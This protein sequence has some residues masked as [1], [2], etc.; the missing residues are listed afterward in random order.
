M[1]PSRETGETEGEV[2]RSQGE[3]R[4]SIERDKAG[5][6]VNMGAFMKG[7]QFGLFTLVL[8]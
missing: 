3:F 1:S 7:V 4:A 2:R 5:K 8:K 6:N